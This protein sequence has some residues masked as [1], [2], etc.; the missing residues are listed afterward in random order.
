MCQRIIVKESHEYSIILNETT[1]YERIRKSINWHC[2]IIDSQQFVDI[3][4]CSFNFFPCS[5]LLSKRSY[6]KLTIINVANSVFIPCSILLNLFCFYI[7]IFAT[8]NLLFECLF[9][10]LQIVH[11]YPEFTVVF[12]CDCQCFC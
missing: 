3:N 8:S 2:V 7:T 1:T 5:L 6:S 12:L 11:L 10:S 4:L 9:I